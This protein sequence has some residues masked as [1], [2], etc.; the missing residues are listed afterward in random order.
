MAYHFSCIKIYT[1]FSTKLTF[2]SGK[3]LFELSKIAF[4]HPISSTSSITGGLIL[5]VDGKKYLIQHALWNFVYNIKL[6]PPI[7]NWK[8]MPHLIFI[9]ILINYSTTIIKI[10]KNH[11]IFF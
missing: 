7:F 2:T 11:L 5:F 3:G 1:F 6:S 9:L 10:T 4:K 8:E